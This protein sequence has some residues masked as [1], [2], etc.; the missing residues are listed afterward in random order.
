MSLCKNVSLKCARLA[1]L[2]SLVAAFAVAAQAQVIFSPPKNISNASGNTQAQQIAVDAKGN[3][4]VI[5]LD[6]SPGTPTVFFSRSSDFGVTFSVPL[7]VSQSG[8]TAFSPQIQVGPEANIYIIW[9]ARLPGNSS[10]GV[11]L[12]RSTDGSTFSAPLMISQAGTDARQGQMAVDSG[13]GISVVWDDSSP[14]NGNDAL[15]F[16]HST[17][18]GATFSTPLNLSTNPNTSAFGSNAQIAVDSGGNIDVFWSDQGFSSFDPSDVLFAHSGDGGATFS[19]PQIIDSLTG[20]P[21]DPVRMGVVGMGRDGTGNINLLWS[22]S[23][24]NG[25]WFEDDIRFARSTDG[26]TSFSSPVLISGGS[27]GGRFAQM[28]VGSKG[29]VNVVFNTNPF[30]PFFPN[31]GIT[32]TLQRSVDGGATFAGAW[33]SDSCGDASGAQLATDAS[34]RIDVVYAFAAGPN[35]ATP[36]SGIVFTQSSDGSNFSAPQKISDGSL[37]IMVV[38]VSGNAY[39]VWQVASGSI[40]TI[41]N[42]FFSRGTALSL[43]TVNLGSASVAGGASLTGMVTLSGPAPT[44]GAVVSLSSSNPSVASVPAS[45]TVPEGAT[46]A[47]FPVTTSTVGAT[48]NVTISTTLNGVTQNSSLT[49]RLVY[50]FSG[51]LPPLLN[52]GSS[53]F[54]SGRTVPVKFQLTATDGSVVT[55]ATA[56]VQVFQIQNT[57]TGTVDQDMSATASGNST[58]GT[59]FRFDPTSN[60]YI[61]NLSTSGYASGTYLLRTT[62][63]DGSTHDV[64]FSIQ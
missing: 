6:S 21:I 52:D 8:S 25:D 11:F 7:A 26:G 37:P 30:Y 16:S 18:G 17:D 34:G 50:N 51:Y 43:S 2:I 38:D 61:Y 54:H 64:Q 19:M 55:N 42:I 10:F 47:T 59:A 14:G 36:T 28:A 12:S 5:W 41:N 15:F 3:I 24:F 31:S 56:N 32:N 57:P 13:G 60:Q 40:N 39:V 23:V 4:S 63:S 35:C 46:S 44:G 29:D 1:V 27:G 22:R 45:V 48:T 62:I 33:S 58:S 49:V 53:L 9:V 20:N